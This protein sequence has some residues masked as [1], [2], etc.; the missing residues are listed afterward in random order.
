MRQGQRDAFF[1]RC[2]D[3]YATRAACLL[4]WVYRTF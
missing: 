1:D 4:V 2:I 3:N